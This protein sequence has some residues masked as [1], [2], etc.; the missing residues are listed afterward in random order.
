MPAMEGIFVGYGSNSETYR[1]WDVKNEKMLFSRDVKFDESH[2]PSSIDSKQYETAEY[3]LL[4]INPA[5]P[6][7][8]EDLDSDIGMR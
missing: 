1:I 8:L 4:A 3:A 2:F 7:E 5:L 6:N